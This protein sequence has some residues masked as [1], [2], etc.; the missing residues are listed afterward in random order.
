MPAPAIGERMSDPKERTLMSTMEIAF[1]TLVV[2]GFLFFMAAVG[3]L[4]WWLSRKPAANAGGKPANARTPAS[5][6]DGGLA[7]S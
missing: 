4:Q 2:A 3:G 7:H 5:P 1:L 6:F